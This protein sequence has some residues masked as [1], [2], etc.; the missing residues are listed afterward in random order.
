METHFAS[1]AERVTTL[2]RRAAAASTIRRAHAV[3]PVTA[4]QSEYSLWHREPEKELG[5]G[6]VPFSPLG[7]GFRR[8][9]STKRLPGTTKLHR[10]E[11]NAGAADVELSRQFAMRAT[12]G[13]PT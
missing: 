6:F 2:G 13:T 11:E 7:K 1:N 9:R 10:F 4:V 3:Q 12:F 8:G 5:I